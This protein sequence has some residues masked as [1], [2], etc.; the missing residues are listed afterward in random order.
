MLLMHLNQQLRGSHH[1]NKAGEPAHEEGGEVEVKVV[2]GN[3]HTGRRA[4]EL[5]SRVSSYPCWFDQDLD[6]QGNGPLPLRGTI[7]FW[8]RILEGTIGRPAVTVMSL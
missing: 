1:F 6:S 8:Y 4:I 5:S 7:S 2:E 3:G